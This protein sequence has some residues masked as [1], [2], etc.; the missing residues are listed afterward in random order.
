MKYII[1]DERITVDK[2]GKREEPE[3]DDFIKSL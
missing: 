3:I 1:K 2:Q